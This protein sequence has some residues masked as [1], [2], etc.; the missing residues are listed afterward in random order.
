MGT[1]NLADKENGY[2]KLKGL[3]YKMLKV[4]VVFLVVAS[5]W[6]MSAATPVGTK[7][8]AAVAGAAIGI[9]IDGNDATDCDDVGIDDNACAALYDEE[10]CDRRNKF[11]ILR[12][13]DQGV[14]PY[15]SWSHLKRND[16]ESL[17]VRRR[18]KLELWDAANGLAT[19]AVPDLVIDRT[20]WRVTS[21]KYIDD[22]SEDYEFMDKKISAYRCTCREATFG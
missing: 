20:S 8:A 9:A 2:T 13:G 3:Q 12:N 15:W 5:F 22:L 10:N 6:Q 18:C 11:K 16:V 14:L 1:S 7:T 4:G 21:N 17:I 19:G